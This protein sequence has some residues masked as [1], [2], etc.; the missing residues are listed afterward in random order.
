LDDDGAFVA[1][2][3]GL[4]EAE[5]AADAVAEVEADLAA[6]VVPPPPQAATDKVSANAATKFLRISAP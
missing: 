6:V 3:A 1:E 5:V 2:L 4:G